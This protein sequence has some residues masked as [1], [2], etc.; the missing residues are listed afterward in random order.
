MPRTK[1]KTDPYKS[2]VKQYDEWFEKNRPVYEA[3][4]SAIR[5]FMPDTSNS[6]EIGVGTGRFAVPLGIAIGLEPAEQMRTIARKRNLTIVGG[7]AEYLPF[8]NSSFDLI[9]MVTTVCFLNDIGEAFMECS[10]VLCKPGRI[11]IGMLDRGSQPGH[12]YAKRKQGNLFYK[13][14]TFR[15]VDEILKILK[16]T[17]F[18]NFRFSQAI[19]SEISEVSGKEPVRTGYG[20]GLFA[21][22]C[23]E[24]K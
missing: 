23:G 22:I 14:A 1:L 5:M 13:H 17:G 21:V 18:D 20:D 3:E 24:K 7:V 10:R 12:T 19:F 11:I 15:S 8:K 6:L 9:L 2:H 4:L 16:Q